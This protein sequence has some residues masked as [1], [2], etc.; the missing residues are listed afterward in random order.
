MADQVWVNEGL[1]NEIQSLVQGLGSGGANFFVDLVLTPS[2]PFANT[3]T[4]AGST[5]GVV[6]GAFA[7]TSL[8]VSGNNVVTTD[9]VTP[10]GVLGNVGLAQAN[11]ITF[12]NVSGAPVTVNGVAMFD[13]VPFFPAGSPLMMN[14][15]ALDGGPSQFPSGGTIDDSCHYRGFLTTPDVMLFANT[16]AE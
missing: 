13:A 8:N 10:L 16:S 6:S 5:F 4:Y 15:S 12:T 1:L 14:L 11:P 3:N 7:A 9:D 2:P